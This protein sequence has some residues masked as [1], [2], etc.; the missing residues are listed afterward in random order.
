MTAVT[1]CRAPSIDVCV[2]PILRI[3]F[4]PVMLDII[5]AHNPS[6]SM[7]NQLPKSLTK[8]I[9]PSKMNAHTMK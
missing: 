8:V 3:A 9:L 1:G 6:P 2:G 7:F 4:T 5:V